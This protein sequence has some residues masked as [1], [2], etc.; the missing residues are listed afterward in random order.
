VSNTKIVI[1]KEFAMN[2]EDFNV[3]DTIIHKVFGSGVI[4]EIREDDEKTRWKV[5]FDTEGER[6]ILG[7]IEQLDFSKKDLLEYNRIKQ[8]L[9]DVIREE[10]DL[11][12]IKLGDKWY[13]GKMVLV[14]GKKDMKEKEFPIEAFFHK[15][16]M[17]RDRLRVMEQNINSHKL[18]D[19]E[20]KVNLQQY[21]TRIY[22]SLTSF[23]VLFESRDDWF[24]GEKGK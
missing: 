22:G 17:V 18:L 5:Q 23:N 21:I 20:E 2:I 14:P 10:L 7:N 4:K 1:K 3:G 13:G 24:V 19:D 9:R 15:I 8:A 12:E 11:S 6:L 16:V